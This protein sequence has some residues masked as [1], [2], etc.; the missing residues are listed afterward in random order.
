MVEEVH[1]KSWVEEL[2]GSSEVE[3]EEEEAVEATATGVLDDASRSPSTPCPT[4]THRPHP[5]GTRVPWYKTRRQRPRHFTL[6]V[7]TNSCSP[8]VNTVA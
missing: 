8:V 6:T 3:V 1:T 2:S 7:S 5:H 4:H